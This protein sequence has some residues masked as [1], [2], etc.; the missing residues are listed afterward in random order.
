MLDGRYLLEKCH[1][2]AGNRAVFGTKSVGQEQSSG[3]LK[4]IAL[5]TDEAAR[6]L[7][8]WQAV[9][10]LRHPNLVRMLYAGSAEIESIPVVYA[11]ME[12]TDEVLAA[13]LTDRRLQKDEAEQVAGSAVNALEYVHS[14]G[15]VHAGLEPQ[16]IFAVGETI[17]IASD[18]IQPPGAP[19]RKFPE[20]YEAPEVATNG[21]SAVSDFW[22]LGAALFEV[23]S[24]RAPSA[25]EPVDTSVLPRP[26]TEIVAGC[27]NPDVAKRW[28]A[29]QVRTALHPYAS[30]TMP[31]RPEHS[32]A[33]R[34]LASPISGPPR[35]ITAQE[36]VHKSPTWI[37]AILLLI[38]VFSI[39]W[40]LV[41]RPSVPKNRAPVQKVGQQHSNQTPKAEAPPV[42][43]SPR[44][45]APVASGQSRVVSPS[46]AAPRPVPPNALSDW[47]VVVYTYSRE[48]DARQRARAINSKRPGLQAEVFSPG[49]GAPP[50]L[51]AIG[52]WMDRDS[53]NRLRQRAIKLGLPRDTYAQNFR[54]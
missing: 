10:K 16:N 40:Y 33:T 7:E 51:V 9:Q 30:A 36:A 49:G 29:R 48:D 11:V 31:G 37:Y 28:T 32:D 19:Y 12:P 13:V 18:C 45:S 52:G 22:L 6:Q 17:K 15:F 23:L 21:L 38:G 1:S 44:K 27:L 50:Y 41:S 8:S 3:I 39:A 24:Q 47:R 43:A 14:N 42:A 34:P 53:A 35:R 20:G 2:A 4:V 26:F 54:K 46:A 5:E 25:G